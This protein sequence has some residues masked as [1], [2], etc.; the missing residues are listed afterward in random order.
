MIDY[1]YG[2]KLGPLDSTCLETIRAW[3][4]DMTIWKWCRQNDLI[5]NLAQERWFESQDKDRSIHMYSVISAAGLSG[6]CGLTSHE[7]VNRRAE[8][9]LYTAPEMQKQGIGEM[10][11]RTLVAHGFLNQNLHS[12][13]G[14][15]FAGNPAMSIFRKVGFKHEGTKRDAYFKDGKYLDAEMFSILESEWKQP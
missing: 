11:L 2:V 1:G 7:Y 8:F 6:V 13:W 15:S 12:I 9:S 3:R 10:A 4:N 5:S 14:E